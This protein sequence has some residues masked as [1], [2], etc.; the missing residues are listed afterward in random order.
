MAREAISADLLPQRVNIGLS[1]LIGITGLPGQMAVSLE[2]LSGGTLEIVSLG[3]SVGWG[4]G[5][6]IP[7]Q[8]IISA[9]TNATIWLAS[10][11][12]TTISLSVTWVGNLIGY[13]R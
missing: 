2:Y 11:G 7:S 13:E 6:I 10:S 4:Q 9:D 1:S 12:A 3:A 8:S 5:W